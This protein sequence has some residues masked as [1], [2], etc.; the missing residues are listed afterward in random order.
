M[1]QS[2]PLEAL[3]L[4]KKRQRRLY[5]IISAVVLCT[6]LTI[7]GIFVISN[8][9]RIR[10]SPEEA[11]EIARIDIVKGI[12]LDVGGTLY[13]L[14]GAPV[15]AVL[16]A[17]FKT[18]MEEIPS[19]SLG[20]VFSIVLK[21]LPAHL[22]IETSPTNEKTR[23]S[24][25]GNDV[26]IASRLEKELEAGTYTITIDDPY[27][28]KKQMEIGLERAERKRLRVKLEP[29]VGVLE[30]SSQPVG[31]TIFLNGEKAGRTPSRIPGNGG[32][33]AV[34]LVFEN[35]MD[36]MDDIEIKRSKTLV[37][38]DYRMELKKGRILADLEP[39][40][41]SM[42]MDGGKVDTSRPL[43]VDAMTDHRFIYRKP[44]YF[45][46]TQIHRLSPDEERRISFRLKPE[47]GQ[48]KISSSPRAEVRVDGKNRGTTPMELTLSAVPHQII[49][50][51][52]GYRS[53]SKTIKPT[54]G[55]VQKISVDLL[56]ESE[57]RLG[58]APREYTNAFGIKLKLFL[59]AN[60]KIIM[61][62]ARHE[63]GQRANE[64]LR[65]VRLTKPF[66]AGVYE[67]TN[68]QFRKF[69]ATKASGPANQPVTSIG[70]LDAAAFCNRLS[71]EEKRQPFYKISGGRMT[72][73]VD[74]ADGYRL[75]SEAEW[76]WL[77]RKS[78]KPEQTIFSWGNQSVVP[79]KVAN[80]ADESARGQVRFYVPNYTDGYPT[81]APVGSFGREKSGLHDLAGNVSEW[82]HD[83]YS[84]VPPAN[85]TETDPLGR[86]RGLAHVV[87]GANWRSGTVTQLRPAF[88]EGL[89]EGRDDLGF[90]IGRY[91]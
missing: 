56:T 64:L 80:L 17:G 7:T 29:L 12:A 83:F 74:D 88:R 49:L 46:E 78:G 77:A 48:V 30:I 10:V 38:R 32:K 87:K 76:E 36:L 8:G 16:A 23:W 39:A 25:D 19:E 63:K 91:L 70:W 67:V 3:H 14:S 43:I 62:A 69:S 54:A 59:P 68:A 6:L 26:A 33:Y 47:T 82:V 75:L 5:V 51:R 1:N 57:A 50:Q 11:G 45:Q 85:K 18:R 15:I 79:P 58:E 55:S 44:G 40:G 2:N 72:G 9:T 13:S 71:R 65:T 34:R 24:I 31:A 52:T 42:F 90:R 84:I 21:P 89:S 22:T 53:V 41:G 86:Q 35:Y 81:V 28:R 37:R 4:A 73:F 60:D 20:G 27:S 66:Y 61:G